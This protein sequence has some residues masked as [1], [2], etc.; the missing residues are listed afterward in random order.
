M[1]GNVVRHGLV[2]VREEVNRL[3]LEARPVE[4]ADGERRRHVAGSLVFIDVEMAK[5]NEGRRNGDGHLVASPGIVGALDANNDIGKVTRGIEH[6]T[7]RAVE[8]VGIDVARGGDIRIGEDMAGKD[9]ALEA[10]DLHVV[11]QLIGK[12]HVARRVLGALDDISGVTGRAH[13]VLRDSAKD[14]LEV[15]GTCRRLIEVGVSR[16]RTKLVILR[17][18]GI[19]AGYGVQE[20]VLLRSTPASG[21]NGRIGATLDTNGIDGGSAVLKGLSGGDSAV[22]DARAEFIARSRC[23]VREEHNNRL[24]TRASVVQGLLCMGHA[25]VGTSGSRGFEGIDLGGD[26]PLA[27]LR[28]SRKAN[29]AL[30]AVVIAV[31]EIITDAIGVV[32]RK[33][34]DRD[35]VLHRW[36]IN[37]LVGLCNFINEGIRGGLEGIHPCGAAPTHV[38]L[39]GTRCVEDENDVQGRR[40]RHRQVRR[41]GDGGEG[42]QKVRVA[43]LDRYGVTRAREFDVAIR[44]G[45]VSPDAADVLRRI[46]ETPVVPR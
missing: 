25:V 32:A 26:G 30:A 4:H 2:G 13:D 1:V 27:I 29:H 24:S 15:V 42:R 9:N 19:V 36:V 46:L 34:H 39:H 6:V 43:L 40:G 22:G 8:R 35:P 21:V 3:F 16:A 7:G 44:D 14:V 20:L 28:A 38:L 33:L 45:L 23:A 11:A 37:S 18:G 17:C 41:R 5:R 12:R 10:V 31:S